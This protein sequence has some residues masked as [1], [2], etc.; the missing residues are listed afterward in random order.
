MKSWLARSLE[1]LIVSSA[2]VPSAMASSETQ[3]LKGGL[4]GAGTGVAVGL[5]GSLGM[6]RVA[7]DDPPENSRCLEVVLPLSIVGVG[8]LGF[9]LGAL[10]G[11]AFEKGGP[12]VYLMADPQRSTYG[13]VL[14]S[15]FP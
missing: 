4:V 13:A 6:C 2:V 8:A 1:V 3:W 12:S 5:G 11:N 10:I 7:T 15:S 14:S 9:G